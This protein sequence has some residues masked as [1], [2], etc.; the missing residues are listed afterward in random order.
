MATIEEGSQAGKPNLIQS[1]LTP[2]FF[3]SRKTDATTATSPYFAKPPPSKVPV[4]DDLDNE[5]SAINLY[6]ERRANL[7]LSP[8][9][10]SSSS[11]IPSTTHS[12]TLSLIASE[13]KSLLPTLL[14]GIP[15]APP[16]GTL[17]GP[18]SLL[19]LTDF[20]HRC[21]N[22]PP[23]PIRVLNA[24]TLDTALGLP[25]SSIDPKPVLVLNM[26]NAEHGGGGW[27]RGAL[28]QEE[29]ICYRSSLSFTLKRRF[30][31][32]KE[33][34]G[35]YS[36][37]VVVF[38]ESIADGHGLL[39]LSQPDQLEVVSVVSVAAIRDPQTVFKEGGEEIYKRWKD[40]MLMKKKMR[41]CLR[42]AAREAHR[43]LVLGALGCGAFGNPRGEVVKCWKEVLGE[44]EWKG[45]WESV[46]FAVLENG[47]TKDGDGNFGVFWRGLDGV[48]V[49]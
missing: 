7:V 29:T 47:G 37:S 15:H 27:L 12:K 17:Y 25:A 13:T 35:I 6:P 43:R 14:K 23:T 28:A 49:G 31:P 42:I 19:P 9:P 32:L 38:R 46:V 24:D 20:P 39:N 33:E 34:E 40:R 41:V 10:T 3:Y 36:P 1:K 5:S 45:W 2:A 18:S 30:Y 21:P 16:D 11:S 4:T 44:G 48:M 26:A 22:L 8:S